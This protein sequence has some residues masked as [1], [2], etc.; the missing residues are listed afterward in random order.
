QGFVVRSDKKAGGGQAPALQR[1]A[2][3]VG[4]CHIY[5]GLARSRSTKRR[6]SAGEAKPRRLDR[7]E[8]AGLARSA[9]SA[10]PALPPPTPCGVSA[11]LKLTQAVANRLSLRQRGGGRF[12]EGDRWQLTSI[13]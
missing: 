5:F 11:D 1:V 2:A 3:T 12:R 9:L 7:V 13:S 10:Q 8:R 4:A 6:A